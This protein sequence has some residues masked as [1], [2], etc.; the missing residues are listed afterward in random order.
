MNYCWI[1]A[2]ELN[3]A[4]ILYL[5][6]SDVQFKESFHCQAGSVFLQNS[7]N[8]RSWICRIWKSI[9]VKIMYQAFYIRCK[10]HVHTGYLLLSC[11]HGMWRHACRCRMKRCTLK[12]WSLQERCKLSLW[13]KLIYKWRIR[14][15]CDLTPCLLQHWPVSS[16]LELF[17]GKCLSLYQE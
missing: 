4:P 8:C 6:I 15:R 5:S 3:H 7:S 17:E 9:C 11:K 14:I 12:C 2:A 16:Q 1:A 13:V 10:L